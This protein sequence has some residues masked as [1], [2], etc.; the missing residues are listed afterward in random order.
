MSI[1]VAAG[2]G[3]H[4]QDIPPSQLSDLTLK[5]LIVQ[6]INVWA[7]S[8]PKLAIIALLERIL[9]LKPWT[10]I[11]F[12]GLGVVNQLATLA[13]AVVWWTRCSPVRANYDPTVPGAVCG[14]FSAIEA[15]GYLTASMNPVLDIFFTLYPIPL[16]MKLNMNFRRRL[17]IALGLGTGV[18]AS[19]ISIYK[20]AFIPAVVAELNTDPTCK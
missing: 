17:G 13:L 6:S 20:L 2:M 14:D 16:I 15:G 5:I 3:K 18:L 8:L 12:W 11:L 7:C 10:R 4:I 9:R 19:G 1:A